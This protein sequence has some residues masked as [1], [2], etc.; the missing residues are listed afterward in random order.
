MLVDVFGWRARWRWVWVR[1][2]VAVRGATKLHRIARSG[3]FEARME[4]VYG[5]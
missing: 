1:I 3:V 2:G 5:G 4:G